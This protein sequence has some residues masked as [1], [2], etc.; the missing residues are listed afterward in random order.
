MLERETDPPNPADRVHLGGQGSDRHHGR[1]DNGRRPLDC[2]FRFPTFQTL[3]LYLTLALLELTL[4]D[5]FYMFASGWSSIGVIHSLNKHLVYCGQFTCSPL[6]FHLNGYHPKCLVHVTLCI[7]PFCTLG[8][9]DMQV[10]PVILLG[11]GPTS[12]INQESMLAQALSPICVCFHGGER[13]VAKNT[14]GALPL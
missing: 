2:F 3:L 13:L 5:E 4:K 6:A 14:A 9:V 11:V 12:D 8:V 7:V 10:F 1:F